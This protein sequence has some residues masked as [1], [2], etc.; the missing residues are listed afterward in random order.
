LV[1]QFIEGYNSD[2][3]V[4]NLM[5]SFK[6]ERTVSAKLS[7]AL[8]FPDFYG[9]NWDAFWDSITSAASQLN[10]RVNRSEFTARI[11][12][13]HLPIYTSLSAVDIG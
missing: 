3:T 7:D 6:N 1:N 11:V 12:D 10:F 9:R 13:F 4:G 5:T 8:G 2:S